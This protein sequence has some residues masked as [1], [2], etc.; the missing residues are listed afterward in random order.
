MD[1]IL[2]IVCCAIL[3]FFIIILACQPRI[4]PPLPHHSTTSTPSASAS[5]SSSS[6][7][8]QGWEKL[9]ALF[10]VAYLKTRLKEY[11]PHLTN[12]QQDLVIQT[13]AKWKDSRF[14]RLDLLVPLLTL[15]LPNLSDDERLL[16]RLLALTRP[17]LSNGKEDEEDDDKYGDKDN[18]KGSPPPSPGKLC[19]SYGLNPKQVERIS[20]KYQGVLEE[21]LRLAKTP[22]CPITLEEVQDLG[23]KQVRKKVSVLFRQ[24]AGKYYAQL[25]DTDALAHWFASGHQTDPMTNQPILHQYYP[26]S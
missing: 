12:T 20:S 7:S 15:C 24:T 22:T 21:H 14:Q 23:T 11:C 6:S 5:S 26:I 19:T 25:F 18:K 4:S 10:A 8:S 13:L 9:I 17:F 16:V 1:E 2:V 3:V